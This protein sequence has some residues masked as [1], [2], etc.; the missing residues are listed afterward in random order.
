MDHHKGLHVEQAGVEGEGLAQLSQDGRDR[1]HE[2][3][4][5]GGRASRLTQCSFAEIYFNV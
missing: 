1:G 3:G 5:R 2:G 4:G